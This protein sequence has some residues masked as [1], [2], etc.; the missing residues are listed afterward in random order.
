M[1]NEQKARFI[2]NTRT[3]FVV[4]IMITFLVLWATQL[5]QFILSIA[6]LG[7]A[8]AIASKEVILNFG[9]TFYR[10]FARPFSVGDRIEINDMRG[11]VVDIG[12]MSTQML[13]VGPKDYT[14]Q[15]T[16]RLV[17][18]PN[19]TFLS[20]KVYNETDTG[21]EVDAYTLHVF[22]IPIKNDDSWQRHIDIILESANKVCTEYVEPAKIFFNNMANKRQVDP[23][24]VE[25]RVNIKVHSPTE[26]YLLVRVSIP[27][28]L[29]GTIE[30]LIIKD[31]L[32][33]VH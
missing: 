28:K 9:G 4:V 3:L 23:P 17:S 24:W 18:I 25:P 30:Q 20:N 2:S 5:Y 14:Q 16:G 8:M 10:A 29:R 33:K 7:A 31:Y 11:Y 1:S 26:I 19:S 15:Y 13:E 22:K 12:L 21:H 27:I 6:A 32:T